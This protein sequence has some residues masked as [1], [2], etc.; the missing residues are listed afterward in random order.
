MSTK[1]SILDAPKKLVFKALGKTKKVVLTANGYA[2]KTTEGIVSEG[3]IVAEQ[4]QTVGV[5]ALKGGLSLAEAQQ[6]IIFEALT[7]VKKHVVLSKK[8]LTKLIA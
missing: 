1:K 4:W 8:R 7:G 5:K 2:L 6:D 3:I